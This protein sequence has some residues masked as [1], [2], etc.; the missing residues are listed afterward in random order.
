MPSYINRCLQ[1]LQKSGYEA[2]IV[3]G[4]VRDSILGREPM[5]WDICTSAEPKDTK[6]VF[7]EYKTIDIGID[8]GT[9]AVI[10]ENNKVEITTY[11]IDGEYSDS[12]RPDKVEYTRSLEEDLKR[13]D[14]TINALAYNKEAGVIDYFNSITDLKAKT[15]RCVGD[16]EKRFEEDALRIMRA[17][18]FSSQ[19]SYDIEEA[20]L[21]AIENKSDLINNISVE[22]IREEFNKILLSDNP[23]LGMKL[24]LKMNLL[25]RFFIDKIPNSNKDIEEAYYKDLYKFKGRLV[26]TLAITI[27]YIFYGENYEAHGE[28]FL[29]NLKYDNETIKRVKELLI[30]SETEILPHKSFLKKLM[31]KISEESL[32]D[33]IDYKG[34]ERHWRL[35]TEIKKNKEP[36]CLKDLAIGGEELLDFGIPRGPVVGEILKL[37]LQQVIEEPSNNYKEYLKNQ[38]LSLYHKQKDYCN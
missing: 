6:Y 17:V 13:R 19:L 31:S 33:L 7:K 35:V 2:F 21:R 22:R 11:R 26:L 20:T 15:I 10:I 3:G 37:L 30:Y 9:V 38:A 29:R 27:K 12:R 34:D 14:F 1:L 16:P 24:I 32:Q 8:H 28:E 36:Y 25:K 23:V 18:R 5:D 4:C